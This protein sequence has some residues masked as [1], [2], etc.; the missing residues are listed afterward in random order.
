MSAATIFAC[1]NVIFA[2][3]AVIAMP[4]SAVTLIVATV[5]NQ[6]MIQMRSMSDE[7][8]RSNPA[9]KI[10]WVTLTESQLR[11][12]VSSSIATKNQQF[13]V[14]TIG[15]YEAPIWAKKGWLKPLQLPAEDLDDMLPNIREGLSHQGQL[16][17]SPIYGESSMLYYRKDLFARAKLVMPAKPN[18][19]D[20]AH[21]AAQLND[22]KGNVH[23]ICLRAKAGWGE[24]MTLLATIVNAFGG[25][26]FDMRWQP[27]LN[28]Q[29][30]KDALELY[31]NLLRRYGPPDAVKRG[32]NENLSLFQSGRC[33][34][35]VD[36]TVAAGF[37]L[38]PKQNR[39]AH[40]V[41]FARAPIGITDKG[42]SWLWAWALAIPSDITDAQAMAAHKFV[43]WASSSDYI[44]RVVELRGWGL[45]PSGARASIY[46]N[47]NF[48][49]AAPWSNLELDAIRSANPRNAT[50]HPNPY[51]GIQ[52]ATIPEFVAIGDQV[53][54]LVSEAV[55]GRMSVVDVMTQGQRIAERQMRSASPP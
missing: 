39:L 46:A 23:G 10:R 40:T 3:F 34:I 4:V 55:T 47:R 5:N 15:T 19:S 17:G 25:Q 28:S 13:D 26:W 53:G 45:V 29:A 32:Y 7:F 6:H 18:W 20:I 2:L 9:I 30:W 49:R 51:L 14:V 38:D 48:Q 43:T 11:Q 42:S 22:P 41:G 52:F 24:N 50:L 16:Y 8:E 1:R 12:A 37:L 35:W 44:K 54:Q 31:V 33:A 36:A 27:Q 21:F